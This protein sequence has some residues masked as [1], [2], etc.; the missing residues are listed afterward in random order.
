MWRLL[1]PAMVIVFGYGYLYSVLDGE[2][3]SFTGKS[4]ACRPI[5][6]LDCEIP[7]TT[8]YYTSIVLFV[9]LGLADVT[10]PINTKG[11]IL[12]TSEMLLGYV[13]LGLLISIFGNKFARR[14]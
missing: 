9:T 8:P 2:W 11:Q 14:S 3:I 6:V 4:S 5:G 1:V 10:S 13:M 7:W 12:L